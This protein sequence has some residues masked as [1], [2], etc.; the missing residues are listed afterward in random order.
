[1]LNATNAGNAMAAQTGDLKWYRDFPGRGAE[2]SG[3]CPRESGPQTA[4]ESLAEVVLRNPANGPRPVR[5]LSDADPRAVCIFHEEW[6]AGN[7][8]TL[9]FLKISV[10]LIGRHADSSSL[11]LLSGQASTA[12]GRVSCGVSNKRPAGDN[13]SAG[14]ISKSPRSASIS[15]NAMNTAKRLVGTKSLKAKTSSPMP[16]EIDV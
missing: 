7:R 10:T 2:K 1:M 15:R 6:Q 16:Q 14:S 4:H 12:S 11:R 13:N 3:F 8:Q 9:G 5:S